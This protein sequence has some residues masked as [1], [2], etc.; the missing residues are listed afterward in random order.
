MFSLATMPTSSQ[1][2]ASIGAW[3]SPF[4]NDLLPFA[5][6]AIGILLGALLIYFLIHIV[7]N[8]VGKILHKD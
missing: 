2:M 6:F 1:F 4:F 3:S 5:I 8:V 7:Q